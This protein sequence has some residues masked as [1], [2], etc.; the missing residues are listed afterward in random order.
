[1]SRGWSQDRWSRSRSR[2]VAAVVLATV[3]LATAGAL[4][5]SASN[6][7]ISGIHL[8]VLVGATLAVISAGIVW[9]NLPHSLT[10]SGALHGTTEALHATAN[11][12]DT[13]DALDEAE[14]ADQA[15]TLAAALEAVPTQGAPR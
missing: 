14:D 11:E 5:T 6:A 1:M 4:T 2:S 3:W 15:T 8:A 9:R 13:D 10:Q 7:F 12:H